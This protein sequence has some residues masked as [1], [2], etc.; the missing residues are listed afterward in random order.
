MSP[1]AA[2]KTATEPTAAASGIAQPC[3]HTRT[4]VPK[5]SDLWGHASHL[6]VPEC[7]DHDWD[8]EGSSFKLSEMLETG[9]HDSQQH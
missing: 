1:N 5:P 6:L 7:G 9:F 8:L 2:M 4:R 3:A